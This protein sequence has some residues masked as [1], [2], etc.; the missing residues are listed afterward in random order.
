MLQMVFHFVFPIPISPRPVSNTSDLPSTDTAASTSFSLVDAA[1]SAL[2]NV[3][4]NEL[5]EEGQGRLKVFL[6]LQN[7]V[8]FWHWVECSFASGS[9]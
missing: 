4:A 6:E 1:S 7:G 5:K 9:S 8:L 3:G 2:G